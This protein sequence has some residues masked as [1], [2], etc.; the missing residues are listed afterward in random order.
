MQLGTDDASLADIVLGADYDDVADALT[1]IR[2]VCA[3]LTNITTE[4]GSM[5]SIQSLSD[6]LTNIA[7]VREVGSSM[8][9]YVGATEVIRS[10]FKVRNETTG[11]DALTDPTELSMIVVNPDLTSTTYIYGVD[12][13]IQKLS[14]GVFRA[15][16]DCTVA[17][18][19]NYEWISTGAAK[20]AFRGDFYVQ[21]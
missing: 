7:T 9:L 10:T 6:P 3:P 1:S 16:I 5:T 13:Q 8:I 2:T 17:G 15:L 20:G 4:A 18:R 21:A 14:K 19:W 12:E 11:I